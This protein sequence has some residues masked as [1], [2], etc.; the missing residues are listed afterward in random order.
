MSRRAVDL[1]TA[2]SAPVAAEDLGSHRER[3]IAHADE[4]GVGYL[5]CGEHAT[6]GRASRC[7]LI[8]KAGR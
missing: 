2:S 8:L 6:L 4:S 5:P 3:M 7:L 1:L